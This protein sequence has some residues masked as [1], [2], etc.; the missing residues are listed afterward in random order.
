M[1]SLKIRS[2]IILNQKKRSLSFK[3]KAKHCVWTHIPL[4]QVDQNRPLQALN[5]TLDI[6]MGT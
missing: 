6:Q 2:Q 4:A 1:I 3:T 5:G